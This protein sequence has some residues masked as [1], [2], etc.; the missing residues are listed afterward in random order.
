[1]GA[2]VRLKRSQF[3]DAIWPHL[4]AAY[5]FARW[6][7]RNDHDAEDVV[8]DSF[9]R[10]FSAMDRTEVVD[11]KSWLLRIVRNTALTHLS[12]NR[13]MK[14]IPLEDAPVVRDPAPDPERGY[15]E[16]ARRDQIRAAIDRLPPEFRE[17]LILR[18]IEDLSYKEIAAVLGVPIGTVMSRLAR[19]R[20]ILLKQLSVEKQVGA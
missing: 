17:T 19:A 6:M 10:A 16:A 14:P 20:N 1:L 7:M 5:S 9:I 15:S 18:D 2:C 3:E 12:R 4:R 8:Q 13:P 11:P